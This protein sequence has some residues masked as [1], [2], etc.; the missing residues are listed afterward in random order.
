MLDGI[1]NIMKDTQNIEEEEYLD[2][3]RE[4]R[5]DLLRD[6]VEFYTIQE[7]RDYVLGIKESEEDSSQASELTLF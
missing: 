7:Q 6:L 5:E 2:I 1:S 3:D 4:L